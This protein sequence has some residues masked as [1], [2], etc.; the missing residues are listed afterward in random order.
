MFLH[1]TQQRRQRGLQLL[2]RRHQAELKSMGLSEVN[3]RTLVRTGD[4]GS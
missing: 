4:T 2:S 3:I 1:S